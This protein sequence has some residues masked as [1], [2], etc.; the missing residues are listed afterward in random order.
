MSDFGNNFV[1]LTDEEGNDQEFEHISTLEH[2]G[3]TYCAFIPAEMSL[4]EEAE[5]VILRMENEGTDDEVL[6]SIDDDAEAQELFNLFMDELEKL[7]DEFYDDD[8]QE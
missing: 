3:K 2:N 7:D 1:V 8:A 6:V 5:V 4:S